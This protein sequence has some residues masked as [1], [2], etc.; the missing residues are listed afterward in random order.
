VNVVVVVVVA[1]IAGSTT[2][3][4]LRENG[5]FEAETIFVSI[6]RQTVR[7]RLMEGRLRNILDEIRR[8]YE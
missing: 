5:R 7:G 2:T 8:L 4:L 3:T 1:E 6:P